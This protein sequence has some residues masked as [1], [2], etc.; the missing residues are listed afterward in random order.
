MMHAGLPEFVCESVEEYVTKAI[1][2][3][4]DSAW[5]NAQRSIL[6]D[7]GAMTHPYNLETTVQSIELAYQKMFAAET[8]QLLQIDPWW[9]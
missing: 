2:A 6:L 9:S 3:Y 7:R 5:T 1:E 8:T 4:R